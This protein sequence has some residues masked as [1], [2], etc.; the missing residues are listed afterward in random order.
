MNK[1]KIDNANIDILLLST[2]NPKKAFQEAKLVLN[3]SHALHYEK[4]IAE[5]LRNLAFSSQSLGF[6]PEGFEFSK[7]AIVLFE[8]LEDKKNLAHVYNT[9]GFIYD[10]LNEQENRL[11][12]NLKSR[13]YCY[14]TGDSEGLIRS[15]NNTGDN[16]I[17]LVNYE[18]ALHSFEECLTLIQPTNHF[19][20]AVVYCNIG[21]VNFLKKEYQKAIENFDRSLDYARKI[22]SYAI[23]ATALLLVSKVHLTQ[24][25]EQPAIKAL[26]SAINLFDNAEKEKGDLIFLTENDQEKAILKSSINIEV[27]IYQLF[28]EISEKTG[29]L[30]TALWAIKKSKSLEKILLAE[31]HSKEFET[32]HLRYEIT[33]LEKLVAERTSE[34][35]RTF[36]ELQSKENNNR[37]IIENAI[38][39]VIIFDESG[40]IIQHNKIT[41]DFFSKTDELINYK[42]SDLLIFEDGT[43]LSV[44]LKS[45]FSIETDEFES[46][47]YEM[48]D[49]ERL[50]FFRV[51]FIRTKNENGLQG[52][53]FIGNISHWKKAEKKR[54]IDL[55]IETRINHFSQFILSKNDY[56]DMLFELVRMCIEEL[57][58][59]TTTIYLKENNSNE[60]VQIVSQQAETY[61]KLDL[62]TSLKTTNY[63]LTSNTTEF[64]TPKEIKSQLSIP[65]KIADELIGVINCGHVEEGFFNENHIRFLM[66][67]APLLANRVDKL[68]EQIQK[69][70]LQKQLFEINQKLEQEVN[71]Q[72]KK[73]TEL[74]HKYL[75]HEKLSLLSELAASISHE[76]NTPFG[77]IKNG[78]IEVNNSIISLVE[79]I[80]NGT[81]PLETLHFV[82]SV[83]QKKSNITFA[84]GRQKRRDL[85]DFSELLYSKNIDSSLVKDLAQAFVHSKFDVNEL[86][87]IDFILNSKNQLDILQLIFFLQKTLSLSKSIIET[88]NSA[89]LIVKELTNFAKGSKSQ[90]IVNINLNDVIQSVL[91]VYKFHFET[92]SIHIE[93]DQNIEILG[94]EINLF[95]L[96][97]NA[98]L[99]ASYCF[100]ENDIENY[101]RVTAT[102]TEQTIL[103]Q[104]NYNGEKINPELITNLLDVTPIIDH[105]NKNILDKLSLI[106]KI[107][108]DHNGKFNIISSDELTTLNFEFNRFS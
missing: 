21:E 64:I 67:I 52:I 76:L 10:H 98:F 53:A 79:S 40:K 38:D 11:I 30:V 46:L 78:A 33:Q 83:A 108:T 73:I 41:K 95:Q 25:R 88:S 32:I 42:L 47:K 45:L 4:G 61:S 105:S 55:E 81:Y 100:E 18:D 1:E 3:H 72:T 17:Q 63:L 97:K 101:I 85:I 13:A 94:N 68:K 23:E 58:I 69:E 51:A 49:L 24:G 96:W 90:E 92:I 80:E 70:L 103:I 6:F 56:R 87:E 48:S 27:E 29:D 71:I 26:K 14:E 75:E 9:L 77:I 7:D 66:T 2:S 91:S 19:M 16:Y 12:A 59:Y 43:K 89:A 54:L 35:E 104:F 107:T 60:L 22:K 82:I 106:K 93:I 37:L 8:K 34:L 50:E 102:E 57:K 31:K 5:A 86:T 15:L 65:L 39:A 74:T 99:L 20:F 84:S 62:L 28:A 36:R 44:V